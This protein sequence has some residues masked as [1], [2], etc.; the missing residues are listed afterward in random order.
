MAQETAEEH[1]QDKWGDKTRR[2]QKQKR[3]EKEKR[4]EKEAF[5]HKKH[6]INSVPYVGVGVGVD[7][8]YPLHGDCCLLTDLVHVY[9]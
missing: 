3:Q 7:V 2:E 8:N 6:G 4:K 5:A 9:L 1:K